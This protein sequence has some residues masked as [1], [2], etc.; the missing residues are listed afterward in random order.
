LLLERR[1]HYGEHGLTL[2]EV[3]LT[4]VI[5]AIGVVG[6]MGGV[7]ASQRISGINQD[8]AQLEA[9]MRQLSDYV[10]DSSS[11]GLAYKLCADTTTTPYSL[12]G[13][14]SA[15]AGIQWSITSVVESPYSAANPALNGGTR[16]GTA[17]TPPTGGVCSAT[18]GDWGV[19][20]ITLKVKDAA[21]SLSRVIWKADA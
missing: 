9:A 18:T 5:M 17:T 8:Q 10:R 7:A 12:S 3:L 21:R 11:Q 14:G 13:A 20:E 4:I 19:Q 15:P 6:V 1:N 16:N 2:I